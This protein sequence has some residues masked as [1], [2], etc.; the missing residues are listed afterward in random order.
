[1]FRPLLF[2]RAQF[3]FQR[4]VFFRRLAARP[5]AGDRVER[6]LAIDHLDQHLG[7]GSDE[8]KTVHV[9]VEHVRR[10]VD[11]AQRTV[12]VKRPDVGAA[13]H[14]VRQHHLDHLAI[15]NV[16]FPDLDHVR[17]VIAAHVRLGLVAAPVSGRPGG[18]LRRIG[19]FDRTGVISGSVRGLYSCAGRRDAPVSVPGQWTLQP[20]DQRLDLLSR[21][22]VRLL[23]VTVHECVRDH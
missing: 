7:R 18:G 21:R 23:G 12:Q 3:F 17:V 11:G 19:R 20:V 22:P 10:G 4:H 14:P 5:C 16:L 13:G 2:V 6:H 9:D 8:L 15:V 1:M